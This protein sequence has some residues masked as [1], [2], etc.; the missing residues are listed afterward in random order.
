MTKVTLALEGLKN[1]KNI[2]YYYSTPKAWNINIPPKKHE[3]SLF[4]QKRIKYHYSTTFFF[5]QVSAWIREK[6]QV[7]Q[8][9]AY[10]EPTNLKGKI[11]KQQ[12][13]EAELATNKKRVDLVVQEGEEL[14]SEKHF[15]SADIKARLEELNMCWDGLVEASNDKKHRLHEAYQVSVLA[16]WF[17]CLYVGLFA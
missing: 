1:K 15:S 2:E 10:R 12:V 17:V 8:D 9:E 11:Q 3:I 16:C 4:H 14:L 6:M 7:A 5:P 13:F